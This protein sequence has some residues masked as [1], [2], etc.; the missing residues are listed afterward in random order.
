M[1]KLQIKWYKILKEQGFEDI[2]HLNSDGSFSDYLKNDSYK[3][4]QR[5]ND[6][7]EQYYIQARQYLHSIEDPLEYKIWHLHS[8]GLS[9]DKILLTLPQ[10]SSRS[11]I[12]R[13]I[14]K[15]KK[16]MKQEQLDTSRGDCDDEE[17]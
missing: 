8:E 7:T 11:P 10:Y 3:L 9:Y 2:E 6:S 13:I 17:E 1:R 12:T 14:N 15:H 16:L 4:A 5:Y